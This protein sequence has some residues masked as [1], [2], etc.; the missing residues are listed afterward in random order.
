MTE[1]H[2]RRDRNPRTCPRRRGARGPRGGAARG[3]RRSPRPSGSIAGGEALDP[4]GGARRASRRLAS[5]PAPGSR[6]PMI[7]NL[8]P[9]HPS[10]H[11]VLRLITELDG[12]V[13]R[14]LHPVIGYL[15]TGIEKQCENK[16]YWQA[17]TLVTR[18]DYLVVVLQHPRLHDRASRSCST[19]RCRPAPSGCAS[20]CASSTASPA[21]WCGSAPAASSSA[22]SRCFFYA[23][24]ERDR[25]LDLGEMIAGERMNTPLLPGGRLRRRHA[26]RVREAPARIRRPRCR[27]ASTSTRGCS[28]RTRSGST[29][30]A[31]SASCRP[32]S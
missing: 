9:Q 24:R 1:W 17:I 5:E 31:G 3:P 4:A 30:P 22:R 20:S 27:R 6:Q 15:H 13:V 7:I 11:G 26:A 8:G 18:M 21:T 12:E 2:Q 23:Y 25:A 29:A 32:T 14:D 19:S 10:T 16:T 28:R